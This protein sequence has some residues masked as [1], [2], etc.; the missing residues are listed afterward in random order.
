MAVGVVPARF[1]VHECDVH[2]DHRALHAASGRDPG[3]YFN[4]FAHIFSDQSALAGMGF[5]LYVAYVAWALLLAILYPLCR[6]WAE[7]KRTRRDWWLSYL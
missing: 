3:G 4:L 5:P 2:D 1:A 6:W 7:L